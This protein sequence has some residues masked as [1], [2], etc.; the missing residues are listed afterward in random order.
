MAFFTVALA[1]V[2]TLILLVARGRLSAKPPIVGFLWTLVLLA[3]LGLVWGPHGRSFVHLAVVLAPALGV[4]A[5]L[6]LMVRGRPV[7]RLAGRALGVCAAAT[8]TGPWI[9]TGLVG[10]AFDMDGGGCYAGHPLWA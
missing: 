5:F 8:A 2:T 7:V 6:L 3:S 4:A 10:V 1:A 9:T